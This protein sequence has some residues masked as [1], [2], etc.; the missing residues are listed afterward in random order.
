MIAWDLRNDSL[1]F[2]RERERDE[3]MLAIKGM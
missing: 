3:G 2:R 1:R